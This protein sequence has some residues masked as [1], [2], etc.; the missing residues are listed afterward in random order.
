M[1]LGVIMK[2]FLDKHRMLITLKNIYIHFYTYIYFKVKSAEESKRIF[3][4]RRT[5]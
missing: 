3:K 1:K 2:N 5:Y 4:E